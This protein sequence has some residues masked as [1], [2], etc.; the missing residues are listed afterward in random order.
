MT[1]YHPSR[2]EIDDTVIEMQEAPALFVARVLRMEHQ[3][4]RMA[5]HLQALAFIPDRVDGHGDETQSLESL[6]HQVRTIRGT[7]RLLGS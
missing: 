2:D 6:Q 3:L 4:E 7:F 1:A 5:D